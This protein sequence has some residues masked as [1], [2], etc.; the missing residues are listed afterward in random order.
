MRNL[1]CTDNRIGFDFDTLF[2]EFFRF[3]APFGV[4]APVKAERALY[5]PRVNVSDGDD[6]LALTIELPGLDKNEIKVM[7]RDGVL[8]V[9]GERKAE[10]EVEADG[11]VRREINSGS[12]SRSFTLPDTVEA[13]KVSADYHNGLL[14]IRLP[15][16]EAARPKEISVKVG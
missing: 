12:F 14:L 5:R 7:V 1:V 15:K 9:S 3:P 16:S 2:N 8:T 13:E 10:T 4:A 11:F 6:E